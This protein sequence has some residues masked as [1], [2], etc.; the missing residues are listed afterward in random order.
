MPKFATFAVARENGLAINLRT[1]P[2]LAKK[3]AARPAAEMNPT[4]T[5]TKVR[6]SKKAARKRAQE[7]PVKMKLNLRLAT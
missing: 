4:K 2:R 3:H 7:T 5:A 6:S 1:S